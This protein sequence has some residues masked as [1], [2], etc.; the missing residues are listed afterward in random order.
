MVLIENGTKWIFPSDLSPICSSISKQEAS[1][2]FTSNYPIRPI[3]LPLPI[4]LQ[5]ILKAWYAFCEKAY[6]P[7]VQ[8]HCGNCFNDFVNLITGACLRDEL[9]SQK[10]SKDVLFITD[11]SFNLDDG[12][13]R[14]NLTNI[15]QSFGIQSGVIPRVKATKLGNLL[16]QGT[17]LW[18][19][20]GN[21]YDTVVREGDSSTLCNK[22][23]RLLQLV[24]IYPSRYHSGVT[25]KVSRASK[26]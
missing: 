10:I 19:A 18:T 21:S 7:H 23:C 16:N 4:S 12:L 6:L 8:S 1:D 3:V 13:Y 14:D 24:C 22:Y 17:P 26:V 25:L 20:I 11:N 9:Q 2:P 5:R 15:F